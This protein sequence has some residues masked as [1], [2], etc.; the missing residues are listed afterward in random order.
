MTA[1]DDKKAQSP[2]VEKKDVASRKKK[3]FG[4][5]FF[6]AL[7]SF[8]SMI[9]GVYMAFFY[10]PPMQV[11]YYLNKPLPVDSKDAVITPQ[12][13]Q[14]SSVPQMQEEAASEEDQLFLK[15]LEKEQ[16][17][18][19][20]AAET[21][22]EIDKSIPEVKEVQTAPVLP[23]T[24]E[25]QK[26]QQ[27][28][29]KIEQEKIKE[30]EAL[31]QQREAE[32]QKK[33]EEALPEKA[34]TEQIK[35]EK[36]VQG[37]APLAEKKTLQKTE[38]TEQAEKNKTAVPVRQNKEPPLPDL[39]KTTL[40]ASL[41]DF[42]LI[43][44]NTPINAVPLHIIEPL[45]ELQSESKYGKLPVKSKGRSPSV[46]YAKD[47]D[48][49]PAGPYIAILFSG[50]G[51][52]KNTTKAAV[53]TLPDVVSLSFTPYTSELKSYVESARKAGHETL[54]D[55]PMQQGKF[56][57]TDPGPLGL[58]SGLPEQENKRRIHKILG[59]DVAFIGVTVSVNENFSQTD[60]QMKT[61]FQ[62]IIKRGLIYI[63][64]TDNPYAPL[65][66][67]AV[68][69]DVLISDGFYRAAIRE[70]LEEAKKIAMDKGAAFVR[71]ETAP[72]TLLVVTEWM[73][74]FAPTELKPVPDIF[75]VPLSYY[76]SNKRGK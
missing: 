74:S 49:P 57:E 68:R 41:P 33:Q 53:G 29:D 73:N 22:K 62:D 34:S 12:P 8:L 9:G 76:V 71:V 69:P 46:A 44:K 13:L 75:F 60:P 45:S 32:T 64:G 15:R 28:Q 39:I 11:T 66:K 38:K 36:T 24:D 21:L 25:L 58:V 4:V 6:L 2:F 56:P 61:F 72:I 20:K 10:K 26:L 70:K 55:L 67:G 19:Q 54:L 18:F 3:A 40:M 35:E 30:I 16:E 7:V 52:K 47:V 48:T 51:K 43:K 5:V 27:E 37:E 50:L 23:E 17:D 14:E 42:S 63:D 1:S 59:Q 31:T 65:L